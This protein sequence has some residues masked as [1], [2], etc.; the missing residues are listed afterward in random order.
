[1]S[2][3]F[4]FFTSFKLLK[5]N[6][7]DT[8][9]E[10][11]NLRRF[12]TRWVVSVNDIRWVTK[13]EDLLGSR[14][15]RWYIFIPKM[16]P[17]VYFWWPDDGKVWYISWPLVILGQFWYIFWCIFFHYCLLYQEKS[18]NPGLKNHRHQELDGLCGLF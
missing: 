2:P 17:L 12:E 5:P 18:G 15:A 1:L 6:V 7:A 4:V 11:W 13:T 16:P 3:D 9:I 8:G 10:T 14:V